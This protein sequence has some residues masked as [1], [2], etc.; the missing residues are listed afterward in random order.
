MIYY[1]FRYTANMFLEVLLD[2]IHEG[3]TNSSTFLSIF[4]VKS[5]YCELFK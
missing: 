5:S 2:E 1:I 3:L 4:R